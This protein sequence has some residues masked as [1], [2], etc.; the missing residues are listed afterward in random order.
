MS[1]PSVD[2]ELVWLAII[3][4]DKNRGFKPEEGALIAVDG[5]NKRYPDL[6]D[7]ILSAAARRALVFY[8]LMTQPMVKDWLVEQQL[9]FPPSVSANT[10]PE[11]ISLISE[12]LL[13]EEDTGTDVATRFISELSDRISSI[14]ADELVPEL[15]YVPSEIA[16]QIHGHSH[17]DVMHMP[18]DYA[19]YV[20][21][22]VGD[23]MDQVFDNLDIQC[24]KCVVS[25][26]AESLV[27]LGA[28]VGRLLAYGAIAGIGHKANMDTLIEGILAGI[29]E[30][31]EDHEKACSETACIEQMKG[32]E[33]RIHGVLGMSQI[34]PS[35]RRDQSN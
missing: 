3:A 7:S 1:Y 5:I 30:F 22:N 10:H 4:L 27:S 9:C 26:Y 17:V 11:C 6:D 13:R 12:M 18:G 20:S 21:D 29:T 33:G 16:D 35:K 14:P 19:E 8:E 31:R 28:E 25:P 34:V 24:S 15:E 32:L 2:A 23:I